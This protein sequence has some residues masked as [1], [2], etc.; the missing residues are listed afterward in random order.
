MEGTNRV[1]DDDWGHTDPRDQ[2]N[3]E[4]ASQTDLEALRREVAEL[5]ELLS[6]GMDAGEEANLIDNRRVV[7][8]RAQREV[9][10]VEAAN[11]PATLAALRDLDSEEGVLAFLKENGMGG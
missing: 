11:D 8:E 9:K 1:S 3:Q 4:S 5:R 6:E 7:Q 2:L 10:A